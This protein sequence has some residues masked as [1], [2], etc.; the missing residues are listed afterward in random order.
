[1]WH[2]WGTREVHAGFCWGDLMERA[3]LEDLDEDGRIILKW[4]LKTWVGRNELDY[5]GSG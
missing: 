1:M 4:T 3:H 2:G 5:T